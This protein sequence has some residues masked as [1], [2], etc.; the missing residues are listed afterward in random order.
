MRAA[1][2]SYAQNHE[3]GIDPAMLVD[4]ECLVQILYLW[5]DRGEPDATG[6][7]DES[8]EDTAEDS[9]PGGG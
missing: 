6:R 7:S 9:P 8:I 2:A 5:A 1:F 3:P 4:V